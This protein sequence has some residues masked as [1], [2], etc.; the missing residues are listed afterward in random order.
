MA[1]KRLAAARRA[2]AEVQQK[3]LLERSKVLGQQTAIA[4]ISLAMRFKPELALSVKNHLISLS[5]D[6]EE[7]AAMEEKGF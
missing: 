6:F 4:D 7:L 1:P 3:K 2:E 5:V